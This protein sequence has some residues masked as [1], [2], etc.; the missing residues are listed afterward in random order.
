MHNTV[1]LA[2]GDRL[3]L[4]IAK[5]KRAPDPQKEKEAWQKEQNEK[6]KK[7]KKDAEEGRKAPKS[8]KMTIL[9]Q[10]GPL[11]VIPP[12]QRR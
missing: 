8:G 11:R 2:R 10:E 4:Q 5:E 3:M 7:R 12:Q 6:E 1:P 9:G